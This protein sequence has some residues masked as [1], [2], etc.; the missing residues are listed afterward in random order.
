MSDINVMYTLDK[1]AEFICQ[2]LYP[3][4]SIFVLIDEVPVL[5][6]LAGVIVNHRSCNVFGLRPFTQLEVHVGSA[7]SS[8]WSVV[9]DFGVFIYHV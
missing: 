4:V 9:F 8:G 2:V 7:Q 5:E 1:S 6:V 3:S